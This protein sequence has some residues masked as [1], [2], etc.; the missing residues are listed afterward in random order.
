MVTANSTD[1]RRGRT[2]PRLGRK[3]ASWLAIG[4]L[5]SLQLAPAARAAGGVELSTPYTSVAVEPGNTA[6]FALHIT[7]NVERR[8]SLTVNLVPAGWTATIRG[9]GFIVDGVT[10]GPSGAPDVTLDV[11]VP[12]AATDGTYRVSVR[13]SGGGEAVDTL[14]V[15]LRV[16]AASGGSVTLTTD[17]PALRDDAT[18][19]FPFSLSL[20]NGTPREL[21]FALSTESPGVGWIVSATPSGQ[22]QVASFAVAAGAQETISVS[23]DPPDTVAAGTYPIAVTASA[24]DQTATAEL[25]VEIVGNVAFSLTTPDQRLSA[26]ASA[27]QRKD[28]QVL[29]VNDGTA[30]VT[31]I[32]LA[33]TAPQGWTVEFD[34]ATVAQVA[35]GVPEQVTVQLTPSGSAIAGDYSVTLTASTADGARESI[36]MRITVDTSLSWGLIGIAL[37]LLTLVGLSWVFQRYGRR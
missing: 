19:T 25:Q 18:A 20:E 14:D 28:F 7:S 4:A 1:A 8:V 6:S 24:G 21:T 15:D 33:G 31:T 27:G 2:R 9:G 10:A 5:A 16:A 3:L 37:I 17:N 12:D 11:E 34:P 23:V 13:A 36:E 30:P 32:T 22:T 26:N 29:V 35:P